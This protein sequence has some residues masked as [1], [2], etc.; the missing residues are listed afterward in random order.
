VTST[1]RAEVPWLGK[2]P[3]LGWL[4]RNQADQDDHTEL[5]I[6]ITPRIMNRANTAVAAGTN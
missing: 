6:F 3:L 2:L 5:L 1:R 4:F